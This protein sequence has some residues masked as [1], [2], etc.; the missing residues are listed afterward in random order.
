MGT[1]VP[2]IYKEFPT[3]NNQVL[4]ACH[5]PT[6]SLLLT[7]A[8]IWLCV[9]RAGGL[10][11]CCMAPSI[12]DRPE[13]LKTHREK[14]YIKPVFQEILD[15]FGLASVRSLL[16]HEASPGHVGCTL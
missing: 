11:G 16:D 2:S 5:L 9:R 14:A 10:F 12:Q 15:L 13:D 3:A 6:N 7:F 4:L 1:S 8:A